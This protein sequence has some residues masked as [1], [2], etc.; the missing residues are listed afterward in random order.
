[1][2]EDAAYRRISDRIKNLSEFRHKFEYT[3][4]YEYIFTNTDCDTIYRGV[5][6]R[7][8]IRDANSRICAQVMMATTTNIF[9]MNKSS[10]LMIYSL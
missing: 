8:C 2:H 4:E 10:H 7:N 6:S 5:N 1:M 9:H 3:F